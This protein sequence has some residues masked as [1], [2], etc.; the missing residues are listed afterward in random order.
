MHYYQFNIKTYAAS[1]AH[2]TDGED[3]AYRR[4]IDFYYDTENP[5]PT[6]LPLV[7]RRLRLALPDVESVLNEF[8][9]CTPDGW[10]HAFIDQ[11]IADYHAFIAR[12][13]TN[14]SKGGRGHKA[15]TKP[16]KPNALPDKPSA[17]P[18]NNNKPTT[19]NNKKEVTNTGAAIAVETFPH[20]LDIQAWQSWLG[21]RKGIGKPLKPASW[22]AAKRA[23]VAFGDDQAAVVAQSIANGYQGLFAIKG[24]ANQSQSFR[25]RDAQLASD[26]V[27]MVAPSI[28]ANKTAPYVDAAD[29]IEA[30]AKPK[31][32]EIAHD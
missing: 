15:D 22:E 4:L 25:E 28:A 23:M 10:K 27:A 20:G 29:F 31:R 11:E 9:L 1:T 26:R 17:K 3:L 5:I 8:F 13:K 16:D 32:L 19:I 2:L 18:T 6:A 24:K 14:G 30:M 21:Y 12:Q 7:C